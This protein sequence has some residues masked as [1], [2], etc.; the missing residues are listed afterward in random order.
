MFFK[1]KRQSCKDLVSYL[2][3]NWHEC[4]V[5]NRSSIVILYGADFGGP[6]YLQDGVVSAILKQIHSVPCHW[7]I[8]RKH[9]VQHV[10]LYTSED[11]TIA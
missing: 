3:I 2:S 11:K 9:K 7:V 4:V 6:Q 8:H 10:F 1:K 5:V